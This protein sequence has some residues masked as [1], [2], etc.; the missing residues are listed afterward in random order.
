MWRLELA[1]GHT[2]FAIEGE[3]HVAGLARICYACDRF[4]RIVDSTEFK[5]PSTVKKTRRKP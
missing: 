4:V 3:A 1:C 5:R 2:A